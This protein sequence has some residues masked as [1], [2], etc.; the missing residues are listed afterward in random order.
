MS[1]VDIVY[2][3]A[4]A[5]P[6]FGW[7]ADGLACQLG[8]DADV[9]VIVVDGRDAPGRR[10]HFEAAV[11]GRFEFLHV[12]AKP[13]PHQGPHRRTASDCFAAGSARN[14]GLIH[15]TAPTVA[16][17]DD[18]SLPMPGWWSAVRRAAGRG[19]V[20]GGAYQR[21]WA[22]QV[23]GGRLESS[24]AHAGGVDTR[25]P[26]GDDSRPVPIGGARLYGATICAPRELLLSLNGFD[27]ICGMIGGED[28]QLGL[29]LDNAGIPV[30]YDRSML[31][32]E[33]EELGRQEPVLLRIDP[34]IGEDEYSER[35]AE[36]GLP[37][38][39][40][41]GRRDASHFLADMVLGT[42]SS[43]TFGNYYWL[44]DLTPESVDRTSSRFPERFW[45]DHRPLSGI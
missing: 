43:A 24:R 6:A 20:V 3:T 39:R 12:P 2:P 45:F 10:E 1:G 35:L 44:A 14:T 38:R 7:F 11:A 21:H 29:R 25:W 28:W 18:S 19:E 27:E 37:A 40:T 8:D 26:L 36:F 34:E 30:L 17:V 31:I 9:R 16:F 22:M 23:R 4:R 41:T 42:G 32:I 15:A 13:S 5:E 33:S